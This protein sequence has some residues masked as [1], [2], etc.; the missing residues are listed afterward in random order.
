MGKLGACRDRRSF[1][2]RPSSSFASVTAWMRSVV[3]PSSFGRRQDRRGRRR[4]GNDA[5]SSRRFIDA[6]PRQTQQYA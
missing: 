4:A 2:L 1:T 6:I 5:A 3:F